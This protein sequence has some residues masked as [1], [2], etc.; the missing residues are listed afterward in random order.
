MEMLG[1]EPNQLGILIGTVGFCYTLK[2]KTPK[3]YTT[4]LFTVVIHSKFVKMFVH[5]HYN[6][7]FVVKLDKYKLVGQGGISCHFLLPGGSMVP[8]YVLQLLFWK[9][10]QN[11]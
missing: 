10:S 11:C 6:L 2:A 3:D 5:L 8:R 1:F 9:N 4:K 7:I